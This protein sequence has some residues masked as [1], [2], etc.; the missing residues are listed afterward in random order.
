MTEQ[1][2]KIDVFILGGGINGTGIAADAAGRG[3]SVV[4]CEKA[5]L[6]NAT[7]NASSKLIHGGLRYLEQYEFR[8]VRDALTEREIL[9]NTSPHL[10][11]PLKFIFPYVS[12]MRPKWLIRIGLFLYDWLAG[13]TRV[14]SSK[15]CHLNKTPYKDIL[16][17]TYPIGFS[18][19]DAQTDDSRLVICNALQAKKSGADIYTYSQATEI[20]R[21]KHG[22]NIT[23]ETSDGKKQFQAKTLINATGPWLN[24]IIENL[25]IPSQRQLALSKG[26]HLLIEKFYSSNHAYILQN[27]DKRITFVIP[28]LDHYLMIGTTDVNYSGDPKLATVSDQEIDYLLECCNQYFQKQLKKQ[29]ILHQW[30]GVRP[31]QAEKESSLSAITRDYHIDIDQ[32]PNLPPCVNIF[33]GKLTTYRKLSQQVVDKLQPF[34]SGLPASNTHNTILPGGKIKISIEDFT[35]QLIADFPA[36]PASL[37]QR[38]ATTYGTCAFDILNHKRTL[39]DL[40][41][42]FGAQLYEQEVRYCCE[43]EWAT[44][45]EDILWRR[46]KLGLQFTQQ[47]IEQ[48]NAWID[49][50][51]A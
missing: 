20:K 43:H 5:D 1:I 39:K 15:K 21:E 23:L 46:T 36:L 14:P 40:G 47:Q 12:G 18:Y 31:L 33:G 41:K 51:L 29:D 9:L 17:K 30:A 4:L 3:L 27:T 16:K 19:Y 6:A 8:M 49:S 22:W 44:C 48:L 24:Q 10:T 38:L 13:K 7:S 34:F 25:K 26:S 28:Y 32:Q 42:H 45:A 35:Q 50:E 2:N 37:L 11:K